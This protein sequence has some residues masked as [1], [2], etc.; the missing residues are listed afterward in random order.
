MKEKILLIGAA[1]ILLAA[2]DGDDGVAG[3]NGQDGFNSLVSQTSLNFGDPNCRFGGVRIDS[4]LDA[5]SNSI[6]D[7]SEVNDTSTVC[8]ADT[9]F[10]LQLLHF[11][12]INSE[13]D[14]IDNAPRFSAILD[15]F[16]NIIPN[17]VVLS[18]GGNWRFGQ[19]YVAATND[20]FTNILGV[21]GRG[22]AH[23][24]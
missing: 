13:R 17:T 20:V 21:P 19:A 23:I 15:N 24:S 4:G 5:N 6:L 2:C 22:R 14:I 16:R 12:D 7:A 9:T 3:Q 8:N 1:S 10:Q 18:A 11:S